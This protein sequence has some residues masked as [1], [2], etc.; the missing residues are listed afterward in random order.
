M[1]VKRVVRDGK[2]IRLVE[3]GPDSGESD[4]CEEGHVGFI[5]EGELET[6]IDGSES[7]KSLILE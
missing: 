7:I 5:L 2:Q 1:R 6:N 3:V 4:W